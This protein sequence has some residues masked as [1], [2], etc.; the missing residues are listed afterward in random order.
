MAGLVPA[1]HAV[2]RH[3]IS[4]NC[5]PGAAWMPGTRPGMTRWDC[6]ARSKP[7][8]CVSSDS[9]AASWERSGQRY[10]QRGKCAFAQQLSF[11]VV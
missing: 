4:Q 11:R 10:A 5:G 1:I 9:S 6:I 3:L 8:G 2:P 7:A